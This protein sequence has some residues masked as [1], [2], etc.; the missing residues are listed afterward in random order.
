[1][2]TKNFLRLVRR[3]NQGFVVIRRHLHQPNQFRYAKTAPFYQYQGHFCT[4]SKENASKDGEEKKEQTENVQE[5]T[6]N[7]ADEAEAVDPEINQYKERIEKLESELK[8]TKDRLMLEFAD[9][10]NL[11]K[12]HLKEIK[13]T[14]QYAI[15]SF[16]KQLLDVSDN[17]KRALES[18]TPPESEFRESNAESKPDAFSTLFEGVQMTQKDLE[19]VFEKNNLIE[20]GKIGETFDPNIHN[21]MFNL[22][23]NEEG[24]KG[25]IGQI[26]KTGFKFGD[27]TLRHADVGVYN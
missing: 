27:R 4:D 8:Q 13:N 9:T 24:D 12:R 20:F 5:N 2:L 25:K 19:K 6:E 16:A 1:M 3:Q 11:R 7:I 22:P 18:I 14:Q 21:A 15:Q 10:E 17:L 26:L 23:A